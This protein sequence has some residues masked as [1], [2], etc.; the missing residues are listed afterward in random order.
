MRTL[1]ARRLA[2]AVG[3][4]ILVGMPIAAYVVEPPAHAAPASSGAP[5]SNLG[6]INTSATAAAVEVSPLTPGLVGAGD[7]SKGNLLDVSIPYATSAAST[8]PTTAGTAAP[9]Y[10]GQTAAG[11]GTALQTFSSSFPPALVNLLNDHAQAQSA[12]PAQVGIGTSGK[13]NP[14]GLPLVGLGT[15]ST[16]SGPSGTSSTASLTDTSL[17]SG[18]QLI[19]LSSS[20]VTTSASVL[21][22]SVA[23]QADT[24]V[25]GITIGGVIKI[26]GLASDAAAISD[27]NFG[28]G[29]G[30]LKLG[31][32]TV[33]GVPAFIGPNGIQLDKN[34]VP[35]PVFALANSALQALQQAGLSVTT[36]APTEQQQG[37]L[38]SVT[39]GALQITFVDAHIPNP[40]GRVPI[41][42]A[43]L[44]FDIGL[45]QASADATSLPAFPNLPAVSA[46]TPPPA[47]APPP[48]ASTG[49]S[50]ASTPGSPGETISVTTP[51]S[52]GSA[53]AIATPA[54]GSAQAP[55]QLGGISPASFAGLP[56]QVGWVIV[57]FLLSLVAAGPLLAYANWQLLRG[58]AS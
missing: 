23:T 41:S 8:G 38:A 53:P 22:S 12:Y 54:S 27:G 6:G 37:T 36:I 4:G 13:Y 11:A 14:T 50:I 47:S 24:T 29:T 18:A 20:K 57:A 58:R 40:Q 28:K 51:G 5:G 26:E 48:A 55:V 34:S 19:E 42:S 45:T 7:L 39:S 15:A 1:R 3:V 10:P 44:E 32:V 2:T 30:T 25:S 21:A 17:L 9:A 46:S 56:I 43:G 52:A 31:A 33:E 49:A 16:N 35:L